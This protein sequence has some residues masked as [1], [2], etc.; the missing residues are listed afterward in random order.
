VRVRQEPDVEHQVRVSGAAVL[1][2]E[3]HHRHLEAGL[4]RAFGER[5]TDPVSQVVGGHPGGIDDQV[6]LF[7]QGLHPRALLPDALDH[8]IPRGQGVAPAGEREAIQKVFVGGLQEQD[9]VRDG[10][11]L[12]LGQPLGQLVEE[13]AAPNVRHDGD[14]GWSP[15]VRS[16]LGHLPDE[17]RRQVVDHE[18]PEVLEALGGLGPAGPGQAGDDGEVH[19]PPPLVAARCGTLPG[20]GGH[21]PALRPTTASAG[22]CR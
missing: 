2:A 15:L 14:Q 16:Q 7:L 18:V 12:E 8:P 5:A 4:R 10:E 11:F 1:E 20:L 13:H 21:Q 9:P 17:R 22:R 6:G 3:G 19:R